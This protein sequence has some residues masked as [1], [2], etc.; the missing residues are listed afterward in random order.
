MGDMVDIPIILRLFIKP[1]RGQ[2]MQAAQHLE[3]IA[4]KG[5]QGDRAFGRT[6]RQVL[7]VDEQTLHKFELQPGMLR[8]N[9]TVANLPVDDLAPGTTLAIGSTQ[10]QITG[11][12]DPC[13]KMDQIRPGL[14]TELQGQRGVLANVITSGRI[15]IG[16]AIS[17]F[18][19]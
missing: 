18:E 15:S 1:D 5:L 7:L 17:I 11:P 6:S 4:G 8:E 13:W 12:C 9:I 3:A 2:P 10:L 16:D 19:P 14:Q